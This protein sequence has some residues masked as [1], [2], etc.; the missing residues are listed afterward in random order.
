MSA[1]VA[2]VLLGS[3][4]LALGSVLAVAHRWLAVEE[5]PRVDEVEN[6]LPGSNCGACGQPGCRA[7]AE[8]LVDGDEPPSRCTVS[9]PD[10]VAE[11]AAFLG[12][13]AG[14]T[15]KRVARLHC[16][17]GRERAVHNAEWQG[18]PSCRAAHL[19][20]GGGLV[21]SW[22]CLGLADCEASCTFGAISM[23]D[24]LLPVVDPDLCTACGDCVEACPRDLFDLEPLGH[25]LLVQCSAPLE[26]EAARAICR[27]VCDACGRC[28]QDAPAGLVTMIGGLPVV[29]YGASTGPAEPRV[30][31][32]C[33]TGAIQWVTGRQFP[34]LAP[35]P[36]V[37][38]A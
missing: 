25:H 28:A 15:V 12:V 19:A 9:E 16:A 17:G 5:D 26:A 34:D 18:A 36:E 3:L 33:P 1:L 37:P 38:R 10:R 31:E 8:R 23:N 13:D 24:V 2:P 30:V 29:D 35:P 6:L 22:G 11:I 27:V 32:R 14:T 4:G 7:F 20:G 21:C